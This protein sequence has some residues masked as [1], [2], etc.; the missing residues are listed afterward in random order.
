MF[1]VIIPTFN[2]DLSRVF[3]CL[4][5]QTDQDFE[6]I[7]VDDCS[8]IPVKVPSVQNLKVTYLRNEQNLGPACSRDY[9]AR[10]A[11]GRYLAFLDDD[12]E[13]MPQK[14]AVVRSL[15]ENTC[16]ELAMVV[17][18]AEIIFPNE[19]VSY[20]SSNYPHAPLFENLLVSNV[21]GGAPLVTISRVAYLNAGGY[22]TNL[23]A[24]EDYE[25]WL[26]L[27]RD[28][29][30]VK[31]V[32]DVLVRCYYITRQKSVSKGLN[33]RIAAYSVINSRYSSDLAMLSWF[34]QRKRH[35][36]FYFSLA[37]SACLMGDVRAYGYLL[38][39]LW[40]RPSLK[41]VTVMTVYFVG[42]IKTLVRLRSWMGS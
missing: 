15:I 10:T 8:T 24:D 37:Y 9:G 40:L 16:G 1:S 28:G 13:W 4:L 7:I 12:D 6:V 31:Y 3:E 11:R 5:A 33:N 2:R 25:L 22:D 39:S 35:S 18:G 27:A 34:K 29:A 19:R 14:L 36:L 42:G 30:C 38:R 23:R 26:R 32:E 20:F 17:H 21:V 41:T